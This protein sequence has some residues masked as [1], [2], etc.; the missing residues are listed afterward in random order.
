MQFIG[1]FL[2]KSYVSLGGQNHATENPVTDCRIYSTLEFLTGSLY[3]FSKVILTKFQF[4][5]NG[6]H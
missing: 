2:V 6:F 5:L 1:N 4:S 3:G